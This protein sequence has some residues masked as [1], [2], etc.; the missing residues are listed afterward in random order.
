MGKDTATYFER[1]PNREL[2]AWK[3]SER[4]EKLS[5]ASDL[6]LYHNEF[7]IV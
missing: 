3:V 2:V 5:E 4:N 1:M 7:R 6:Q